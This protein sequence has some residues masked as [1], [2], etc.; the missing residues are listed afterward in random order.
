M[1]IL[2]FF[3]FLICVLCL[4]FNRILQLIQFWIFTLTLKFS[5]CRQKKV[6][7]IKLRGALG[8]E[9]VAVCRFDLLSFRDKK[10][11]RNFLVELESWKLELGINILYS[12]SLC[13]REN[14]LITFL[15]RRL[16]I[17]NTN[18]SSPLYVSPIFLSIYELRDYLKLLC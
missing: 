6:C 5:Y 18:L 2:F 7:K 11:S 8:L 17:C 4:H 14:V 3:F 1:L 16:Y 9:R 10:V 13:S 12:Q 15:C